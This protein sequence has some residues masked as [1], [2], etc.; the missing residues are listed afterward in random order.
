MIFRATLCLTLL[1]MV[2]IAD[3]VAAGIIIELGSAEVNLAP[4]SGTTATS[5]DITFTNPMVTGAPIAAYSLFLDIQPLGAALPTGVSFADPAA[6][7]VAGPPLAFAFPGTINLSPAFGDLGLGELQL[8]N[9]MIGAGESFDMLRVNL[10]IDQA[11]ASP[12]VYQISLN[13]GGEN[14][15][16]AFVSGGLPQAQPFTVTNGTL[17]LSSTTVPVPEPGALLMAVVGSI[18]ICGATLLRKRF[19]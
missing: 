10:L 4:G 3:P 2:T 12:G 16:D 19:G 9:G 5:F 13:P 7:Y 8:F 11:L 1:V 15:I 18:C 17:T 6:T 14:S